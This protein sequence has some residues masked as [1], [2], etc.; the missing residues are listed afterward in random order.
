MA[1]IFLPKVVAVL[2]IAVLESAEC[3]LYILRD[4]SL[5]QCSW[6]VMACTGERRAAGVSPEP[7]G[8]MSR[9]RFSVQV[10]AGDLCTSPWPQ[11]HSAFCRNSL[12]LPCCLTANSP[13]L[14][15][16]LAIKSFLGTDELVWHLWPA[17]PLSWSP[18][19]AGPR[20]TP[21]LEN[22]RA[23]PWFL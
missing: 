12:G 6:K 22:S 4:S 2:T 1:N 10:S 13:G 15:L 9:R 16:T 20:C 19:K 18:C 5:E 3:Y 11:G 23:I 7:H 14:L 21:P 8:F 17:V